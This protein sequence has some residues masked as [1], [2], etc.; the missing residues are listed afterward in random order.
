MKEWSHSWPEMTE[1]QDGVWWEI[2]G[3]QTGSSGS[4][5]HP[6]TFGG[7]RADTGLGEGRGVMGRGKSLDCE[8][9]TEISLGVGRI[10]L[11]LVMVETPL[12]VRK[13]LGVLRNI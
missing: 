6:Q 11:N 1:S 8:G 13:L 3:S 10:S 12:V 2:L 4:T 7:G 5:F 9:W